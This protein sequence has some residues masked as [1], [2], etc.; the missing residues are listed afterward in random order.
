MASTGEKRS[1]DA[2]EQDHGTAKPADAE[3]GNGIRNSLLLCL[4]SPLT[5]PADTSSSEDDFGPALPS[6]VPKKKRRKLPY[7]KLYIASLPSANSY[8]KSLMHR[9]QICFATF[10]PATDFL[11]TS[12]LDGVV[13]FWKKAVA[14]VEFV[15]EFRAHTGAVTSVSVSADGQSFASAGTDKSVKIFDVVTFDLVAK[16]AFER[17][18]ICVCWVHGR[19][20]TLPLLAVSTTTTGILAFTMAVA[21]ISSRF[22]RSVA[23]TGNPCP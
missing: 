13:K 23:Y 19:S 12:S 21:R 3:S 1:R 17:Q 8:S 7:E 6:A 15:K 16:L 18:P 11:I 14:D 5:T 4:L 2:M 9:D 10:T 22:T 20:A